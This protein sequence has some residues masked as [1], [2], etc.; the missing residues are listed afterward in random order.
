MTGFAKNVPKNLGNKIQNSIST[1]QFE[2]GFFQ[3]RTNLKKAFFK[4]VAV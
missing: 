3:I 2:K 1:N 4:L